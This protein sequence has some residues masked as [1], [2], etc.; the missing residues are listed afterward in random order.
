MK[1]ISAELCEKKRQARAV[2]AAGKGGKAS[3]G[4]PQQRTSMEVDT[5]GVEVKDGSDPEVLKCEGEEFA[6]RQRLYHL[7]QAK[8][9]G[10]EDV[11]KFEAAV[12]DCET[13]TDVAMAKF[14]L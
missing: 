10:R 12:L 9:V 6:E 7:S 11:A 13:E 14:N 3:T 5:V 1:S 2:V 4:L 8:C